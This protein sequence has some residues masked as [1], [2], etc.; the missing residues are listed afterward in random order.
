MQKQQ[1]KFGLTKQ[2]SILIAS[3]ALLVISIAALN[4]DVATT[5]PTTASIATTAP[6]ANSNVVDNLIKQLGSDSAQDRDSAQKQLVDLG[7]TAIPALKKAA[8]DNDDPEIRSR[9]AA[10][11]AQFKDLDANGV[12]LIT[13]H[14]QN[15]PVQDVLNALGTQSH[16]VLLMTNRIMGGAPANTTVT[17]NADRKPF[18]DVMS[19]VCNQLNV[20]PMLELSNKN[21]MQLM[22]TPR[23]WMAQ[24]PHQ[25]VGPFR[26]NVAGLFRIRSID[27]LGPEQVEDQFAVRL[28]IVPEPKL[29]VTQMSEFVVKEATDDAGHSLLPHAQATAISHMLHSARQLNHT[30]ESRLAYP[31]EGAGKRI[32]ILRGEVNVML[33]QDVQQFQ[34]EDVLGTPKVINPIPGCKIQAT[35]TRQGTEMFRVNMQCTRENLTD[36]QWSAMFNRMND[37]SLEDADGHA[38]TGFTTNTQMASDGNASSFTATTLFTRSMMGGLPV[39][40][41]LPKTGD[42]KKLTWNVATSVKPVVIPVTF[43]DLPMP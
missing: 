29:S 42:P 41:Q 23:N 43:K 12:S 22:A 25:V 24:S 28:Q 11:L 31:P 19:D 38:L 17:L 8:D 1:Y 13:L 14:M 7:Q 40:R 35:V 21:T 39:N 26:I 4:A 18:W 30:I 16:A 34:V 33:A 2:K 32:A 15:A 37:L 27:L 6:S 36:D 3:S 9:A 20:C 10:A 5:A